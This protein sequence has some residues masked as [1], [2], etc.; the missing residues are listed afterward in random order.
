MHRPPEVTSPALRA[1]SSGPGC[2]ARAPSCST[3]NRRPPPRRAPPP[4]PASSSSQPSHV[5]TATTTSP[6][7][8]QHTAAA[9]RL[10]SSRQGSPGERSTTIDTGRGSANTRRRARSAAGG[11]RGSV[12][13]AS[14]TPNVHR[15]AC[16]SRS[17]KPRARPARLAAATICSIGSD[18]SSGSR[19]PWLPRLAP[20]Q[21]GIPT[22]E[23]KP[24]SSS[25]SSAVTASTSKCPAPAVSTTNAGA[26]S[27]SVHAPALS[28]PPPPPPSPSSPRYPL[29]SLH[30][31]T[32]GGGG[33]VAWTARC[34]AFERSSA[35]HG[36][37]CLYSALSHADPPVSHGQP[38]C[39]SS[40]RVPQCSSSKSFRIAKSLHQHVHV[41]SSRASKSYA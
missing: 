32:E 29:P 9:E 21:E 2:P 40:P 12:G 7:R 11:D 19:N 20:T 10:G 1:R 26:E 36:V 15:T 37:Q 30:G 4:P 28:P 23:R 31:A 14:G 34:A 8:R 5:A 13:G 27:R 25:T 35:V 33:G 22:E 18:C 3:Q 41:S 6:A 16:L 17:R 39:A 24:D 38:R